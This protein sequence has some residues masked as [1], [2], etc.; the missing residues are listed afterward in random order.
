MSRIGLTEA[1]KLTGKSP[2]TITRRANHKDVKKRLS[3]TLNDSGEKLYDV[4][5]LERVFGQLQTPEKDNGKKETA[6]VRNKENASGRNDLHDQNKLLHEEKTAL[7]QDKIALLETQLQDIRKDRDEWRQ[8]AQQNSKLLEFHTKQE[9]ESND[10]PLQKPTE[11]RKGFWA[12]LL[13]KK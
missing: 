13:G 7:L 1:A 9:E 2:S 10:K 3:F 12:T 5:E 11:E 6:L 8:L 4:A